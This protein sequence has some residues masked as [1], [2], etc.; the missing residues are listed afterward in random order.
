MADFESIDDVLVSLG[1]V[2]RSI[3]RIEIM[4]FV[5]D[6]IVAKSFNESDMTEERHRLERE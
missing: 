6:A 1:P 3:T 5:D 4:A 2:N